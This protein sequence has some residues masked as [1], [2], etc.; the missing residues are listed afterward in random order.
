M[1]EIIQSNDRYV[2]NLVEG[3]EVPSLDMILRNNCNTEE[4]RGSAD[5]EDKKVEKK[6]YCGRYTLAGR[7]KTRGIFIRHKCKTWGCGVCGPKKLASVK[8]GIYRE[9]DKHEL[10]R[11]LTLTLPGNF[12]GSYQDSVKALNKSWKKFGIYFKREFGEKLIYIKVV[13]PQ[14]RGI[15]HLHVLVSRYIPQGWLSKIWQGIGGGRICDIRF[16]DVH[17]IAAYISKY[18]SKAMIGDD[19]G[20]YRR[21]STSQEI[22]IN[23]AK[24]PSEGVWEFLKV[25]IDGFWRYAV[26]EAQEGRS[27]IIQA[28]SSEGEIRMYEIEY[29]I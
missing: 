27:L 28:E 10:R 16:V 12:K 21:Y 6:K 1:Q 23:G 3:L 4:N 2:N 29:G 14:K 19:L 7:V 17:R 9:A 25:P 20:P 24:Q 8:R 22:S 13:E 18:M 15:A 11:F 5:G 26:K